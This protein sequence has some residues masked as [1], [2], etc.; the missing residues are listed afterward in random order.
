[1]SD[2][3]IPAETNLAEIDQLL[4]T[5]KKQGNNYSNQFNIM[6]DITCDNPKC[7]ESKPEYY[8]KRD[9]ITCK[10]CG[11]VLRQGLEDYTPLSNASFQMTSN[12]HKDKKHLEHQRIF[13][14]VE[15][16]VLGTI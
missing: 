8:P 13:N 10:N 4:G 3:R 15:K 6:E 5:A 16:E 11:L 14:Q 12:E 7:T 1:M 9:E 2:F